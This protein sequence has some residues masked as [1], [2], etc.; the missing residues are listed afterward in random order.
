MYPSAGDRLLTEFSSV[1]AP[2]ILEY[3]QLNQ[4]SA[5]IHDY[6]D[7]DGID[8]MNLVFKLLL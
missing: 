5:S 4:K 6:E 7:V 2:K 1:L 8:L 3:S